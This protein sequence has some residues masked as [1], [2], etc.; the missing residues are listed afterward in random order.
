MDTHG[1]SQFYKILTDTLPTR[2]TES[3]LR[4]V[5]GLSAPSGILGKNEWILKA[6]Y[7]ITVGRWFLEGLVDLA[8]HV[9][10]GSNIG[11]VY[12]E[13]F[14][15]LRVLS[16]HAPEDEVELAATQLADFAWR[17]IEARRGIGRERIS[18]A[19]R[20]AVWFNSGPDQRCYLCGYRFT[21]H[22]RDLFLR[23]TQ[24]EMAPLTLVD[25]TR[26][27][28]LN[29]R[30]LRIELDH[31]IPVAEGGATD[32]DNLYL[33]CG[34]CNLTKSKL[35]SVYDAKAWAAGIVK[36]PDPKIGTV[37]IPQPLWILRLIAARG[38]CE[39]AATCPARLNNSELF[40]APFRAGGA[41]TPTNLM[42]VC[43][44]HDP[45]ASSR[46]IAPSFLPSR[47]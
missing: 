27:R 24:Q 9:E 40:A 33:A 36:H 25:F 14:A 20:Q 41:L 17:E 43:C 16:Q 21:Q 2:W 7:A 3:G 1:I 6:D 18:A 35:W 15:Q 10:S 47:K 8:R 45:W 28:G 34:W 19:L 44:Q 23:R 42:V 12:V 29:A 37:T 38:R 32:E 22:A 39:A 11:H 31:K 5:A 26:P 13:I 46:F 30:H 4:E